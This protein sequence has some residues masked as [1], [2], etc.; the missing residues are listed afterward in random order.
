MQHPLFNFSMNPEIFSEVQAVMFLYL[1]RQM[2]KIH[3]GFIMNS[4]YQLI[5]SEVID[6]VHI[7]IHL[8]VCKVSGSTKKPPLQALHGSYN[9]LGQFQI[10]YRQEQTY[11][12]R[13]KSHQ[14][15]PWAAWRVSEDVLRLTDLMAAH[16]QP[17]SLPDCS[18]DP[19]KI[20]QDQCIHPK[21][22]QPLRRFCFFHPFPFPETN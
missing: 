6:R 20:T 11:V 2:P 10:I 4:Y 17:C 15:L 19:Y 16:L 3:S 18:L 12:R 9:P 13:K 1:L 5:Q 21:R 22:N 7:I 8:S 14:M